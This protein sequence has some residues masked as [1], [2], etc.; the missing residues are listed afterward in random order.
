MNREAK[1]VNLFF[2]L[3]V[4]SLIIEVLK[5]LPNSIIKTV[6]HNLRE[7]VTT[8]LKPSSSVLCKYSE[9][10]FKIFI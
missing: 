5:N 7:R 4:N 3:L 10:V 6:K 8:S 9:R 2:L 1:G